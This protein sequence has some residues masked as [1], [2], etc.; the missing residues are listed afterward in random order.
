MRIFLLLP[1]ILCSY[2]LPAQ[3]VEFISLSKDLEIL[4]LSGKVFVHRSYATVK[5]YGR[6]YSNGMIYLS[7]G[8]AMVFDTPMEEALT[9]ELVSWIKTE[10]EAKITG[11]VV[12]HFHN[13]CLGGLSVFHK[14]N[15]PS[16]STALTRELAAEDTEHLP[17]YTFKKR[18]TLRLG[19]EKIK[20][21]FPGEAHTRDNMVAWLPHEK[22]L[23]GGCMLK[24]LKSGK[25]NLADANVTSW[26]QTVSKVKKKFGD[27]VWA[28]PGHGEFGGIEL[29]DYTIEMFKQE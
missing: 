19:K 2:L 8:E 5:P 17:Q 4:K 12:N 16:W 21:F 22:V 25:G 28:I 18:K 11:I 26:S 13:D 15:I 14:A 23:F 6:F 1:L 3:E 10:L 7:D 24:S 27:A 20:L 29:L 9:E